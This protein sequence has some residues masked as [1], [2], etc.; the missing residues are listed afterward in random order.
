MALPSDPLHI[1]LAE[2]RL[3]VN[4][5][6]MPFGAALVVDGQFIARAHNRQLQDAAYFSHAEMNCLQHLPRPLRA[7]Q[8]AVLYATEAPC[9][10]CAGA[11]LISGI[12]HVVVG[13]D[14]H[15]SGACDWLRSHGITVEIRQDADCIALVSNFRHH[16]PD[17]W[18]AFSAG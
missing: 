14:V 2:A 17:R 16:H 5:G 8:H 12:R 7:D 15:Y 18:N 3:S 13:E 11:V 6:G 9:P 1:A 10:M 4:E